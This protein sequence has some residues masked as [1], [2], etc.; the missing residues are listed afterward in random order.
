[1][2]A[3]KQDF[4]ATTDAVMELPSGAVFHVAKGKTLVSA[5]DPITKHKGFKDIFAPVGEAP[6]HFNPDTD[7]APGEVGE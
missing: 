6:H 5:G 7:A 1:M 2:A 4:I 3:T